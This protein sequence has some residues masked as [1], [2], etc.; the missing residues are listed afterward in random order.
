MTSPRAAGRRGGASRPA[1]VAPALLRRWALPRPD[2]QGDKES[3]GRV[4][5]V[6]GAPSLP[7]AVVLAATAAL[8]AGAGKLQIATCR[9]IATAVGIAVP[10]SLVVALPETR[11]G[12]IAA[13]GARVLRDHAAHTQALLVGPGLTGD[14]GALLAALVR[15]VTGATVVVDAGALAPLGRRR[16]LLHPLAGRAVVTPH[17]AEMAALLGL[18]V[19]EVEADAP[20]VAR[21]A[22]RE[23]RA[24]VA[25]KGPTT[26]VAAPDGRAWAY[27]GGDVGLATSGSGDTLAG[28]VAG[29]AARGCEPAQAA[30]WAVYTHGAAGNALAR[31]VGR[32]GFL[33]RELLAEV[34]RVLQRLQRAPRR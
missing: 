8:R 24:V 20:A 15:R 6:G 11:A 22:A 13:G 34:P 5:V 18:D 21:R 7:G 17:A 14:P 3:R 25:L 28:V 4:L 1:A 2:A 33:A 23:L 30:V 26:V 29:L 12:A 32:V 10:E 16:T 27:D 19:G 31:R 9:S